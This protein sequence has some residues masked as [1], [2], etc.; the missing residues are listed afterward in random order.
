MLC[1]VIYVEVYLKKYITFNV[2]FFVKLENNKMAIDRNL[3]LPFLWMEI[4]IEPLQLGMWHLIR[5]HIANMCIR[6]V[7][8][9]L[10]INN[11]KHY[12]NETLRFSIEM[13]KGNRN[14]WFRGNVLQLYPGGV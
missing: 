7:E 2:S 3:S 5:R 14:G 6:Y 12:G 11:Y 8:I 4:S 13:I 1:M 9:L 10:Q